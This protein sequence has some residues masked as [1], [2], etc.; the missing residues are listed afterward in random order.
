MQ[1]VIENPF[2]L[3]VNYKQTILDYIGHRFIDF[4][5]RRILQTRF[6]I[7]IAMYWNHVWRSIP[8]LMQLHFHMTR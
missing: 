8:I 4:R 3:N 1:F 6:Y 5:N 7:F 2:I